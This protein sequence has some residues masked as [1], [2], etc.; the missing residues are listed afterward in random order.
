MMT[1]NRLSLDE[2]RQIADTIRQQLGGR[3]FEVMTGAHSFSFEPNGTLMFKLPAKGLRGYA[4]KISLNGLDLYDMEF[5]KLKRNY[6][7]E[8]ETVE[9]V[10][11]DQLRTVFTKHTGLD[12]SL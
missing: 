2:A 1:T 9:N 3:K 11:D 5:I 12:T 7:F 6:E 8:R 4:V 10:Y